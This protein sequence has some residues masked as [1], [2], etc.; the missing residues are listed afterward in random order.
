MSFKNLYLDWSAKRLIYINFI[1]VLKA[2][3]YLN[4]SKEHKT[5]LTM[6][7]TNA[8]IVLKPIKTLLNGMKLIFVRG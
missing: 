5:M 4:S 8:F 1:A 2:D 6:L 7:N 3:I